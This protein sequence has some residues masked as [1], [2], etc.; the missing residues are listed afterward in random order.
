MATTDHIYELNAL[1]MSV[2]KEGVFDGILLSGGIDSSLVACHAS[3]MVPLTGVTMALERA[4]APDLYYSELVAKKV[5]INHIRA[6]YDM[7]AAEDAMRE[8]VRVMKTF[9][10]VEIR[11]DVTILLALKALKEAGISKVL[12]GDGGDELFA[13]Y[14]YMLDMSPEALGHHIKSLTKEWRFSA[15]EL[16]RAI[17]VSVVPPL[18]NG[19]IVDFALKLPYEYLVRARYG[20]LWGKW[21]LRSA[22]ERFGLGE[23]AWREKAPI[24]KGSGSAQLSI[25]LQKTLGDG[26][27]DIKRD[28][29]AEGVRFWSD[30]QVYFYRLYRELVGRIPKPCNEDEEC[31]PKC[32]AAKLRRLAFCRVCG[33]YD[34][35]R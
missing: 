20:M 15:I 7:E 4:D 24:E 2:L 5:H 19:A 16:G 23:V 32:G 25:A 17:G 30:E 35:K 22:L 6:S 21:I 9:D 13:G 3:T 33:Y 1:I 12:T 28:A 14:S 27:N 10:H 18:I 34:S 29:E 31:C 8:V 11:N 26:I